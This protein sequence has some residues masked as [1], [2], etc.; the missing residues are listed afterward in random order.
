MY[1]HPRLTQDKPQRLV[2]SIK[3]HNQ[4][5]Q[6]EPIYI[7]VVQGNCRSS[8]ELWDVPLMEKSKPKYGY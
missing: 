3:F 6:Q 2:Y 5:M 8:S 1:S 7:L 4:I